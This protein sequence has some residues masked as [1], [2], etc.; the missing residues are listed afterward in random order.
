MLTSVA[1]GFV[2]KF[3]KIVGARKETYSSA[4]TKKIGKEMEKAHELYREMVHGCLA[5]NVEPDLSILNRIA[6]DL[7]IDKADIKQ[8][9][10][11]DRKLA[12]DAIAAAQS[13][14]KNDE[15]IA[16]IYAD[17]EATDE[18]SYFVSGNEEREQMTKRLKELN[19]EKAHYQ[20]LVY[21]KAGQSVKIS[22]GIKS[23][24]SIFPGGREEI[25]A[26]AGV[27]DPQAKSQPSTK[28]KSND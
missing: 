23:Q 4:A 20:R 14:A 13:F 27:E 2:D 3:G 1:N 5:K 18:K 6:P 26:L 11:E 12:R 22:R 19:E 28:G 9:F 25:F 10:D 17:H 7:G 24:R 8:V 15:R 16:E 21:F